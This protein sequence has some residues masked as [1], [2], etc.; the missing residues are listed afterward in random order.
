MNPETNRRTTK[1]AIK[2]GIFLGVAG[3][4]A[5]STINW[6]Y[7]SSQEELMRALKAKEAELVLKMEEEKANNIHENK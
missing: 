5:G 6:T 2:A 3:Y 7:T 1:R 4:L